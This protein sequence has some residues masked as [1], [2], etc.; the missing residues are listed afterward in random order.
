ML[1]A[2]LAWRAEFGIDA[3]MHEEFDP[4]LFGALAAVYGKDKEGRPVTYNVYGGNA[5]TKAVFADVPRFVRCVQCADGRGDV[6]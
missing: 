3:L 1:S 5:D 4:A 2:T 6:C